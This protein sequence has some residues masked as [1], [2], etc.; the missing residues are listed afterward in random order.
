[1]FLIYNTV[2]F[3]VLRRRGMIGTLRTLGVTRREVFALILGE[4]L[5]TGMLGTGIG[6]ALGVVMGKGLLFFVTRT[7]NDLYFV[8]SVREVDIEYLSLAKG[9]AVGLGATLLSTLLPAR[10][11]TTSPPGAVLARSSIE[12]GV[13]RSLPRLSLLGLCFLVLGAGLLAL[14][15]EGIVVAH[16]AFFSIIIGFA[17]LTP[18]LSV[19]L[20]RLAGPLMRSVF[21][22]IGT[23]AAR[24]LSG[25]LSRTSVAIAALMVAVSATVGVGIMVE[26][27][28]ETFIQWLEVSLQSDIYVSPAR[29]DSRYH[30]F[31]LPARFVERVA[32]TPGVEAVNRYRLIQ[33]ESAE[34]L[35]YVAALDVKAE[36]F[37][38]FRFKEGEAG[39]AWRGFQE[40]GAVILSEP[41]AYRHGLHAGSSVSLKTDAGRRDFPVAGVIYD[42]TSDQGAV[43]ISRGWFEKF[44]RDRGV[45]SLGVFASAGTDLDSL[46]ETL[47]GL[48]TGGQ[49]VLIRPHWVLKRESLEVFDR[50]FVITA[51]LRILAV[52][53]AF[54]G[55]VSALMAL[56]IARGREFG[57]LR[58]CGLTPRQGWGLIVCE[59]ALMGGMAGILSIPVG[60]VQALIMVYVINVRSFG[61][62]FKMVIDP[63]ILL[64]ALLL[65][66]GAALVSGI[67]PAMRIGKMRPVSVL[68]EE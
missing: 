16:A 3:M 21:G 27:F 26:S 12:S 42:Y 20:L 31:T 7:I 36:G 35:T 56:Q 60:L 13:R 45:T 9:L 1:M 43:L 28:R 6:L 47:R 15:R 64:Q 37:R 33:V 5:V 66:L 65:A 19:A 24:S 67:Y 40:K 32:A 48:D 52:I 4:A 63:G 25:A 68:R 14:S 61:W 55:V 38:G 49:E 8:L 54:V 17:L 53:V 59:S 51:V 18:A 41:Y 39:A 34:G 58:A 57:I 23:M 10:E 30:H 2:T 11:A 22:I 44:W 50:T 29:R 62:T 46:T